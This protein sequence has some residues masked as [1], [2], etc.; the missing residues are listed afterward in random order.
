M[1]S[2]SSQ[3]DIEKKQKLLNE[4]KTFLINHY[5]KDGG[6]FTHTRVG[7]PAGVYKIKSGIEGQTFLNMYTKLL[8]YGEILN[9]SEKQK[10]IGPLMTDYDFEFTPEYQQRM[11]N[12][13]NIIDIVKIL[14]LIIYKYFDINK[15]NI[16]AYVTEKEQP[17]FKYK[18]NEL[19]SV[20]D[21]FHICYLIPF[22]A[23]QRQF[24]YNKLKDI[25]VKNNTL[26]EIPFKNTYNEILDE[27]TI[28]RNNWMMYGST[29][30]INGIISPMYSLTKIYDYECEK[31]NE[32]YSK[33]ELISLFSV[34]Q[35]N[36]Q[37]DYIEMKDEYLDEF[38][39]MFKIEHKI[40]TPIINMSENITTDRTPILLTDSIKFI[41]D[42][43]KEKF[44]ARQLLE[45]LNPERYNNYNDWI[46][47]GWILKSVSDDMLKD[48]IIFSKKSDKFDLKSCQKVWNKARPYGRLVT[49]KTLKHF[50]VKDNPEQY[51]KIIQMIENEFFK[52]A[53]SGTDDDL[54]N[55][56]YSK[57]EHEYVCSSIEHN[58]WYIFK[59]H[60][61]FLS[62]GGT[63]L[64]KKISNEVANDFANKIKDIN[65]DD[66]NIESEKQELLRKIKQCE[67]NVDIDDIKDNEKTLQRYKRNLKELESTD[68]QSRNK[69]RKKYIDIIK[70]LKN[71]SSIK[72]VIELCKHK[73]YNKEFNNN[74]NEDKYLI[75]FNN[76][77]YD[78]KA[79]VFRDGIPEDNLSFSVGYDYV[80]YNINDEI[81]SHIN[82]YFED[83][84]HNRNVREYMLRCI[85]SCLSG[86][87]LENK[88]FICVGNGSNGKS[89]MFRLFKYVFGDYY[90]T[91]DHTVITRKRGNASSASPEMVAVKGKRL[92]VMA[93][94]EEDEKIQT[95]FMK[96]LSGEDEINARALYKD[97]ITF[98]PQFKIFIMCNVLP[99]INALDHGTWRRIIKIDFNTEFVMHAPNGTRPNQ[100]KINPKIKNIID[101]KEW[102]S[103][104]IWLLINKYYKDYEQGTLN[105]PPEVKL[106]SNA[107][108]NDSN[109]YMEF[110]N[111]TYEITTG[112][113]KCNLRDVY[114]AFKDWY[115][116]CYSNVN[117]PSQSKLRD[118]FVK[119]TTVKLIDNNELLGLKVKNTEHNNND[120]VI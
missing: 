79:H 120:V 19:V 77:V 55:Y 27:S 108:K 54:A 72:G 57:Y 6:K 31:Y 49:L 73:F 18:N 28:N 34:R 43:E 67:S 56:V 12:E 100:V 59:N 1:S 10:E 15:R 29:K 51:Y 91:M 47:I 44:L 114:I 85:A 65:F 8:E 53:L 115:R 66:E 14:N 2:V 109:L 39:N 16:I 17:T 61:W 92:A 37:E 74:L 78:L 106:S 50:A 9:F 105:E 99:V 70:K 107:Y 46:T 80:E 104:L 33:T 118:Y 90:A 84:H 69:K 89:L 7:T 35:Y 11:Y 86:D 111:T 30:T 82:K 63:D 60:R 24:I 41:N 71:S 116:L 42:K 76:G 64:Y 52:Q 117:I 58:T 25:I 110:V 5:R 113:D 101:S 83:I 103:A 112:D 96:Q 4:F 36:K 62:E 20:K 38:E 3:P 87:N 119:N 40:S 13:N 45:I 26:G 93:E 48:F 23:K 21:G 88:I 68:E 81:F 75:G 98:M 22:S 32:T 95:G 97:G 102:N 94:L